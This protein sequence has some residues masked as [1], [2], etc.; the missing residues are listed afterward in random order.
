MTLQ[1]DKTRSDT[2]CVAIIH[3]SVY[4]GIKP[5]FKGS[6]RNWELEPGQHKQPG[7]SDEAFGRIYPPSV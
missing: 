4:L 1:G 5:F 2:I 3:L 6:W 7:E